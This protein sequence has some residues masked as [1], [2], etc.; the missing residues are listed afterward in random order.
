MSLDCLN[1]VRI[2]TSL[3][4]KARYRQVQLDKASKP[5]TAFTVGPLGF[6][7][8][9]WMP[10]GL[11]NAPTTLQRLMEICFGDLHLDYYIIYLDDIIIYSKTPT[12]HISRL[13]KVFENLADAGF[14]LNPSNVT[15]SILGFLT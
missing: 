14:K 11:T 6:F 8:C 7:E 2:F 3:N 4:L 15:S 9:E 5:L 1:G 10:F 12:R 13:R